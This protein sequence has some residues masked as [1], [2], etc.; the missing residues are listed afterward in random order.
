MSESPKDNR[1]RIACLIGIGWLLCLLVLWIGLGGEREEEWREAIFLGRFHI[2]IVHIPIG[3]LCIV[4]FLEILGRTRWFPG[5]ADNTLPILW[6][7]TLGAVSATIA[8]YLLMTGE[9][10]EG[11][12]MTRHMWTGFGVVVLSV[13]SIILKVSNKVVPIYLFV[14]LANTV[15]IGI[16]SHFGGNMVH[17]ETYLTEYAPE[18]IKKLLKVEEE[19]LLDHGVNIDEWFI[20]DDLIQPI[21]DAK[22]SECHNANKIKGGLRMDSFEWLAKGGDITDEEWIPGDAEGSELYYRVTLEPNDDDFMPPGEHEAMTP[23]EIA[24][25]GW[26]INE[27]GKKEMKVGETKKDEIIEE[28]LKDL[29]EKLEA[30][31]AAVTAQASL[32]R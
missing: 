2:L 31:K 32:S 8:G 23:N 10:I 11:H 24:L 7:G 16:S 25:L 5:W 15:L 4:F 28:I 30:E 6:F 22:C 13:F 9:Q 29:K 17:S 19:T 20:Y 14:L 21:F 12:F 3:L 18:P 26:W 27:G 1:I